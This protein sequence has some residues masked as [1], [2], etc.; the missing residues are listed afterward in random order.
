MIYIASIH[1]GNGETV[2]E[3]CDSVRHAFQAEV[4]AKQISLSFDDALDPAR[5]Q[6]SSTAVLLRLL[7]LVPH[8]TDKLAAITRFDLFIPVLTFVFGEAQLGGNV[9]IA[10]SYRLRDE[11]YGL[12]PDPALTSSRLAKEVIHELGHTF[13]LRHCDNY[14]CAMH[15]STAVEEIDLKEAELCAAC[16]RALCA[17]GRA[18]AG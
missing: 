11:F 2:A 6:Y 5:Q 15:P 12:P 13:G 3:L 14:R 1:T 7:D 17:A 10:S 8:P 18:I 9:A 16:E 4:E